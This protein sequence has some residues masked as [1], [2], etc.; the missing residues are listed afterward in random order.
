MCDKTISDFIESTLLALQR[1]SSIDATQI[2]KISDL[3]VSN[4]G[5][6]YTT[7]L[8]KSRYLAMKFASSLCSVGLCVSFIDPVDAVHGDSGKFRSDDI[9]VVISNSGNSQ[10]LLPLLVCA[11]SLNVRCISITSAEN[12]MLNNHCNSTVLYPPCLN[13]GVSGLPPTTS[14]VFALITLDAILVGCEHLLGITGREFAQFH[15]GGA[16][17][18]YLSKTLRD[19]MV[20]LSDCPVVHLGQ[21]VQTVALAMNSKKLGTAVVFNDSTEFIGVFCDGDL[22]RI[23]SDASEGLSLCVDRFISKS[24][25]VASADKL[26]HE[27]IHEQVDSK[28]KILDVIVLDSSGK[29]LGIVT[30]KRLLV[31]K[32][33]SS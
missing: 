2:A 9:L 14:V 4:K 12:S 20:P 22:R 5:H 17:G 19:I 11:T 31:E 15:P 1:M 8:G 23:T 26:V 29:P 24:P 28:S 7:G 27:Y 21:S 32:S 30:V 3:L 13:M 16:I 33:Y 6:C 10:E 25:E 18:Q